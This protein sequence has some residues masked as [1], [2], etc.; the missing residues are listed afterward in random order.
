MKKDNLIWNR[1]FWWPVIS[2]TDWMAGFINQC[3]PAKKVFQSPYVQN[4][5]LPKK[6]RKIKERVHPETDAKGSPN[7]DARTFNHPR[8]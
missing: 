6:F 1:Y 4:H 2:L 3:P 8:R 5:P 7:T